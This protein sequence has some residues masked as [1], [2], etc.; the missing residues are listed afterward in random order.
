MTD[1]R[2]YRTRTLGIPAEGLKDQYADGTA[3]KLWELYIGDKNKR[4]QTYR[5]FIAGL[6][7][8][9]G[10]HNI[11][12]VAC[13]TGVDSIML[14][15]E[16]FQLTSVDLS[17]KMLKYALKTR[18][19]R[20]KETAF[21]N[22]VIEEANWLT[23]PHDIEGCGAFD[24]VVCLGNS[25]AHLPDLSGDQSEHR[26]ALSNFAEMVKP[27]GILLIDHRNY[28]YIIDKGSAPANNIYYNSDH[29]QDIKT[30]VLYVNG[31]PSLV[32][33]DYQMDVSDATRDDTD[34]EVAKKGRTEG[35]GKSNFR[36]SY[37]PHRVE[38]FGSL[39]RET[40][41][42]GATHTVYGDFVPLGEVADPAFYIHVVE[43][44]A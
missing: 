43:K 28:D 5:N 26:M 7:R 9:K 39:L 34:S 24:A 41:G 42:E 4:T 37:Y 44:P 35:E 22:W 40:F 6:L 3:A 8:K 30:S 31:R 16:G 23:L 38:R 19:R 2:V 17:D 32:T 18:W 12:D 27:G 13:G 10:C 36:L 15:E 20:R 21:D 25:F 11:L 33:L 1:N 29:I 14:L